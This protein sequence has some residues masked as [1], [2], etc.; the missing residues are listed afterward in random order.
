[1]STSAAV[2]QSGST[3][4][5]DEHQKPDAVLHLAQQVVAKALDHAKSKK[6]KVAVAV[7]DQSG[8]LLSFSRLPTAM[9]AASA[10]A[11]EKAKTAVA[12]QRDT[13]LLEKA[14]NC[15]DGT[16]RTALLSSG[17]VLMGGGV[18]VK[19]GLGIGGI[20]VSGAK[21]EE[22]HAVAEAGGKILTAAGASKL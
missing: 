9:P 4:A 6:L 18:F 17:F 22:D 21:P 19:S 3:S 5:A 10:I 1:M 7:V 2:V 11:I 15:S 8:S 13:M 12:F 20:G 16:A 14:S